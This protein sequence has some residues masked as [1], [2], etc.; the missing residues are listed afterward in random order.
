[1]G[2]KKWIEIVN[3]Q[4]KKIKET[5]PKPTPKKEPVK[6]KEVMIVGSLDYD[7]RWADDFIH[8]DE[9]FYIHWLSKSKQK[10]K[11]KK[12]Y[13]KEEKELYDNLKKE[14]DK[15]KKFIDPKQIKNTY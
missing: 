5:K 14:I 3:L 11:T 4:I 12:L 2:W 13:L 8:Y 7:N 15:N 1:M 10:D 6:K 9:K